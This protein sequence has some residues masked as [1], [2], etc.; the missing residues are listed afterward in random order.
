MRL[1]APIKWL[2]ALGLMVLTWITNVL[3]IQE[4]QALIKQRIK[5]MRTLK[6]KLGVD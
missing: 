6:Q 3:A 5:D 2:K 1:M 4:R